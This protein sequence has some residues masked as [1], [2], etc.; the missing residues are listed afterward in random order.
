MTRRAYVPYSG[1]MTKNSAPINSPIAGPDR[2]GDEMARR[3]GSKKASNRRPRPA[4][5][6]E[7]LTPMA[8]PILRDDLE[9]S[10]HTRRVCEGLAPGSI[11]AGRA[12][13]ASI[14]N[15]MGGRYARTMVDLDRM[16]ATLRRD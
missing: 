11:A 5:H 9:P 6:Q 3:A 16:L 4:E 7:R 13:I 12:W 14:P 15:A 10:E 1:L 2:V 8:E